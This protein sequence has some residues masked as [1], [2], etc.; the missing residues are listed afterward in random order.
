[1]TGEGWLQVFQTVRDT[2]VYHYLRGHLQCFSS[3]E[4]TRLHFPSC[5]IIAESRYVCHRPFLEASMDIITWV[6]TEHN[7]TY[8]SDAGGIRGLVPSLMV[9]SYHVLLRCSNSVI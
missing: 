5:R 4:Q 3:L 2:N 8:L 7:A 6:S 1:M 9:S